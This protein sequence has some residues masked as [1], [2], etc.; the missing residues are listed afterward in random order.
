MLIELLADFQRNT[1]KPYHVQVSECWQLHQPVAC[2]YER[3]TMSV[4]EQIKLPRGR[5][6]LYVS[7]S[8]RHNQDVESVAESLW[9]EVGQAI[10]DG[11]YSFRRDLRRYV[12]FTNDDLAFIEEAKSR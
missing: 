6:A 4:R 11:R 8:Y 12:P 3:S 2:L 10:S 5:S 1:P 7:T 9:K